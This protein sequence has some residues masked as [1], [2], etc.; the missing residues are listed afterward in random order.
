MLLKITKK[1]VQETERRGL[2]G[3][4]VIGFTHYYVKKE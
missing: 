4:L 2:E 3:N 1:L